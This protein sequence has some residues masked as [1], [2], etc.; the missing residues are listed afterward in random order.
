M[1][2]LGLLRLQRASIV[3][4]GGRDNVLQA[5]KALLMNLLCG[6]GF[7]ELFIAFVWHCGRLTR[8]EEGGV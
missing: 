3:C 8:Q 1:V 7:A 6:E 4:F 5:Q 2:A